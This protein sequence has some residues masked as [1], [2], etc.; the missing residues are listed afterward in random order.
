MSKNTSNQDG[1]DETGEE[2]ELFP[3]EPSG[4]HEDVRSGSRH[5]TPTE[6]M[7]EYR[8]ELR[9]RDFGTAHRACTGQIN[10]IESLL[11]E[12]TEISVLQEEK[13]KLIARIDDFA[14]AH[15]ALYDTL[16][17]EEER[18]E[19]NTRYDSLN[20]RNREV[21]LLLER[22]IRALQ[23]QVETPNDDCRS[24]RSSSKKSRDSGRSK[25]SSAM[26]KSSL[27]IKAEMAAKVTRLGTELRFLDVESQ[28][29]LPKEKHVPPM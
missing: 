5:R 16:T 6:K 8:R 28:K 14:S 9:E 10:H 23:S 15:E 7:R 3:P 27:Q 18:V 11:A 21:S 4:S 2:K 29:G 25:R 17:T 12:R 24:T 20:N 22:T 13:G 26:S 19:Q 1:N